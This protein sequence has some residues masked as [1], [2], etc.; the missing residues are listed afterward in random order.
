MI[1]GGMF[2]G[3]HSTARNSSVRSGAADLPDHEEEE[4]L[5]EHEHDHDIGGERRGPSSSEEAE[6]RRRGRDG[7]EFDMAEAMEL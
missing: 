5:A 3:F 2:G 4:E 7:D 1:G 6:E